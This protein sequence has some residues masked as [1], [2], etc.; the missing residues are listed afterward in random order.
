[1]LLGIVSWVIPWEKRDCCAINRNFPGV[2][3]PV[4]LGMQL[5]LGSKSGFSVLSLGLSKV[6]VGA[7]GVG[8]VVLSGVKV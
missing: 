5:E 1:M 7:G 6:E 4:F 3:I 2:K 8:I